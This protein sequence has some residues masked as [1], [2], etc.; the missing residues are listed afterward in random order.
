MAVRVRVASAAASAL[1]GASPDPRSRRNARTGATGNLGAPPKP[2]NWVSSY[3][4]SS[5]TTPSHASG[6]GRLPANGTDCSARVAAIIDAFD[7]TSSRRFRH[8]S[9]TAS[10]TW[11]NAGC[12]W[13]GRGGQYVPA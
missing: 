2:P 11:R 3:S 4:T 6:V 13:A 1:S 8:A 7:S 12:P 10:R 5:R 9:I